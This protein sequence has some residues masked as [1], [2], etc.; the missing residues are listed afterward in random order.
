MHHQVDYRVVRSHLQNG[1]AAFGVPEP[2]TLTQWAEEHFYLSAESSYV[3]QKWEAGPFQR[4]I[5]A[6]ISNDDSREVD[7]KKSARTGYTKMV[8]AAIGYFAEH[9]RRNQ[10]LWQPADDDRDEFV[11]TELDPMLRDVKVMHRVFPAYLARHKDNTLLQNKFL[12]SLLHLRG[13]QAAKNYRR[14]SVDTVYLDELRSEEHT[15]ELQS[16]MRI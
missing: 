13:G 3:E 15:S 2:M 12:G 16:L 6:C 7:L 11:K 14:I 4:A 8:L 10:A 1:L 5:M 9:K